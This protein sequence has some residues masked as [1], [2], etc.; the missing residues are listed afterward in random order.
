MPIDLQKIE[1]QCRPTRPRLRIRAV[2]CGDHYG[3]VRR[4]VNRKPALRDTRFQSTGT[5]I[6]EALG[7]VDQ[8]HF[9]VGEGVD[10]QHRLVLDGRAVS[11]GEA[12]A[13]DLN[14]AD[15]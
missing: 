7:A 11:R 1:A 6:L 3:L 13:A 10:A 15:R 8:H 5:R 9:R 12:H 2:L 14:L 4:S